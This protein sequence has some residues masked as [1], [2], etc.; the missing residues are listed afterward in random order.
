MVSLLSKLRDIPLA[1]V[2]VETTGAS[3]DYGDRVTEIGIVRIDGNK[4]SEFQQLT[5][6]PW[7]LWSQRP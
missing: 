6:S 7:V 5:A 3:I 1:F 4:P 2:D